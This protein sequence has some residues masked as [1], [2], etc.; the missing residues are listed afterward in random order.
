MAQRARKPADPQQDQRA[1]GAAGNPG[2]HVA[3]ATSAAN[4][5]GSAIARVGDRR[6]WRVGETTTT[7]FLDRRRVTEIALPLGAIFEERF[8]ES[9]DYTRAR[10]HPVQ[11]PPVSMAPPGQAG[12][13]PSDSQT[14]RVA[15][16]R[17]PDGPE[18][19]QP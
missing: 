18:A 8:P 17:L 11:G 2:S 19:P 12:D 14:L 7:G 16:V 13:R 5:S 15:G 6:I 9:R 3:A 4:A 1:A 10:V